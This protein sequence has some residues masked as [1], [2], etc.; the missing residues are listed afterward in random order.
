MDNEQS[1]KEYE[2]LISK[3]KGITYSENRFRLNI[4][5]DRYLF[6]TVTPVGVAE[7]PISK[8]VNYRTLYQTILDLDLKIKFSLYKGIRY[9]YTKDVQDDFSIFQINSDAE[10]LSYYY[11]E[12]ALCRI[13]T[14]WDI[15]AQLYCLFYK[16]NIPKD[17]IHYK[18][19]FKTNPIYKKKK[20]DTS[21]FKN[22][23]KRI[24]QYI[25][26]E[27]NTEIDGEWKGNHRYVNKCRNQMIHRNSIQISVISDYDLYFKS[28]PQFMLKRIIEDYSKVSEFIGEILNKME[29]ELI[30]EF[31]KNT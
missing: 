16:V 22:E 12:N 15:L 5:K 1:E 23:A 19:I 8:M 28:P 30:N 26:E 6:G 4:G 2:Y 31:N 11:I 10:K 29:Q 21:K 7:T 17:Q 14:V 20:L 13:S 18:T 25:N 27:D 9:A 24:R 3:I